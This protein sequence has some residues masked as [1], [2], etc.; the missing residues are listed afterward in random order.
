MS[1]E[2]MQVDNPT[3]YMIE[4]FIAQ[5][6]HKNQFQ[7]PEKEIQEEEARNNA[8]SDH[9]TKIYDRGGIHEKLGNENFENAD[10]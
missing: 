1:I 9:L 10:L 4:E 3:H 7:N 2:A 5:Y 8:E 6:A